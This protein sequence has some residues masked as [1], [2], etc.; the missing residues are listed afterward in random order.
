MCILWPPISILAL[1]VIESAITLPTNILLNLFVELP[2]LP[3]I[4]ILVLLG[5]KLC[6]PESISLEKWPVRAIEVSA[7]LALPAKVPIKFSE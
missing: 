4:R 1:W 2:R 7:E 6:V 3:L 5:T